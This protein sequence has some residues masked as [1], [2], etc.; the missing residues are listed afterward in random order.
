MTMIWS[1][2]TDTA[3]GKRILMSIFTLRSLPIPTATEARENT[4]MSKAIPMS[5]NI[6]G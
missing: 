2:F 4:F 6:G 5:M 3:P 1:I